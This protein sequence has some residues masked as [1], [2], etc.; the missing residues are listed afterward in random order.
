MST[1]DV[2]MTFVTNQMRKHVVKSQHEIDVFFN[3]IKHE[4]SSRR[5]MRNAYVVR[6]SGFGSRMHP[7]HAFIELE[8]AMHK[9]GLSDEDL[10]ILVFDGD[11][12]NAGSFTG[13][14][15]R[16]WSRSRSNTVIVAVRGP[17]AQ[18]HSKFF[19]SWIKTP[20]YLLEIPEEMRTES[21]EK[22]KSLVGPDSSAKPELQITDEG[23]LDH[24]KLGYFCM[25][26][27]PIDYIVSIGGGVT[28]GN[29]GRVYLAHNQANSHP[30][31]TW[32]VGTDVDRPGPTP[33]SDRESTD[34]FL[35][36]LKSELESDE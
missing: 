34:P 3:T 30:L 25:E 18:N 6:L 11:F 10:K 29:E 27:L 31:P 21:L 22:A 23:Q 26:N 20:I 28:T 36:K 9:I 16:L 14:L 24:V 5:D 8:S 35:L 4:L 19:E 7:D 13:A 32:I 17:H 2:Q 12:Y 1:N 15:D 33:T